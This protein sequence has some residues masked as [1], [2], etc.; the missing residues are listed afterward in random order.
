M[1]PFINFYYYLFVADSWFF[2]TH[3]MHVMLA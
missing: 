3:H 1:V 2:K